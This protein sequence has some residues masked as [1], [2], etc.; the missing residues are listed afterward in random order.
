MKKQ[1]WLSFQIRVYT[2]ALKYFEQRRDVAKKMLNETRGKLY[3]E[4]YGK[5]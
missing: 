4:K 2:N 3:E 5:H 1:Y